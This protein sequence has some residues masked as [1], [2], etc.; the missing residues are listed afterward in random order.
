MLT[1]WQRRPS[2]GITMIEMMVTVSVLAIV[3]VVITP[4]AA[5]WVRQS[6]VRSSAE[7]LRS[8]L[9]RARAEAVARNAR[10]RISLGNDQ[11]FAQWSFGCVRVSASC[12]AVLQSHAA[13]IDSAVRWAGALLD[14]AATATVALTAGAALPGKV[15]F[16][17]LGDAPHIAMGTDIARIDVLHSRDT[18][19]RRLVVRIDGAGN[20]R[21]CD[22]ALPAADPGGCH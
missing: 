7:N 2:A 15:D 22:P 8:V 5:R 18:L 6:E 21:I 19:V 4:E 20:V 10:I 12:P 16:F 14:G 3:L 11:G 17:P 1:L 13:Q 9:Q